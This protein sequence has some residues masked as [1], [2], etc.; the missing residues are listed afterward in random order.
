M[1]LGEL[2]TQEGV[3]GVLVLVALREQRL[4]LGVVKGAPYERA[5]RGRAHEP[6]APRRLQPELAETGGHHIGRRSPPELAE[7]L[8]PGDRLFPL[9]PKA[10]HG[11]RQL[12]GL[13]ERY[14]GGTQLRQQSDDVGVFG[15]GSEP[16]H[17][18]AQRKAAAVHQPFDRVRTDVL[19]DC[20]GEVQFEQDRHGLDGTRAG[21]ASR[22][23][24]PVA[25]HSPPV[26]FDRAP[27]LQRQ[28]SGASRSGARRS[29]RESAR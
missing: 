15:G 28:P 13:C 8:R 5:G 27:P 24:R 14:G 23:R 6:D 16:A 22:E 17:E 20:P 26:V 12:L 29:A 25:R 10:R 18:R 11:V 2:R 7:G 1:G 3:R 21:W 19:D 4:D 9:G